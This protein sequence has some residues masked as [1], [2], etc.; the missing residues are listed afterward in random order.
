M[1]C[2]SATL[3]QAAAFRCRAQFE[4]AN[5]SLIFVLVPAPGSIRFDIVNQGC[6]KA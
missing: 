3:A 5:R 4:Y 2:V 6:R 1:A